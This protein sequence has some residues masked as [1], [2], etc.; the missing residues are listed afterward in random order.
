MCRLLA[1]GYREGCNPGFSEKKKKKKKYSVDGKHI[2]ISIQ[3]AG[4]IVQ[5]FVAQQQC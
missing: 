1:I 4:L 5:L 3:S 2:N